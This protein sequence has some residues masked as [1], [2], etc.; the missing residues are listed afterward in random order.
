MDLPE[1]FHKEVIESKESGNFSKSNIPTDPISKGGANFETHV[2]YVT[3]DRRI[4]FKPTLGLGFFALLVFTSFCV[5]FGFGISGYLKERDMFFFIENFTGTLVGIGFFGI[6]IYLIYKFLEPIVFDKN[7][8]LYH[9]GFNK[10]PNVSDGDCVKLSDIIA[11]Q[12][13]GETVHDDDGSFNSFELNLVLKNER[14]LN[15]TDHSNLKGLIEDAQI[16]SDY[17]NV[18]IWHAESNKT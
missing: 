8:N 1:G 17:L 12:L 2:L 10:N 16:L 18:P 5:I 7:L 13:L 14:R 9:K 4:K 6:S 3:K 11:I 15:V